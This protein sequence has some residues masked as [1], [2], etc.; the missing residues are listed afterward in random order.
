MVRVVMPMLVS[1]AM[2]M[3][4]IMVVGMPAIMIGVVVIMLVLVLVRVFRLTVPMTV[5][6]MLARPADVHVPRIVRVRLSVTVPVTRLSLH[7]PLAHP[8]PL[9]RRI[10]AAANAAPKPLSMFTTEIPDAHDVSIPRSAASP[11][12]AAP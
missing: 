6:G 4:M 3:L 2:L 5:P 11:S 7:R 8:R 1:V 9:R 10:R 12:N